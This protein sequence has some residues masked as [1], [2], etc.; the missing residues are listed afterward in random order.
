MQLN[1]LRMIIA[2]NSQQ[3]GLIRELFK[4][5]QKEWTRDFENTET[6]NLASKML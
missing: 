2:S 4:M 3:S 5:Y 1:C 6:R